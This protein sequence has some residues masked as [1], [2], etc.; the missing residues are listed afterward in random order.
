MSPIRQI[1]HPTDFSESSRAAF[2][3]ACDWA[4]QFGAQLQLLHVAEGISNAYPYLGPPFN[5]AAGW[6]AMIRQK[7]RAALNEWPHP[8]G[9]EGME[10]LRVLR[11]GSPVVQIAEYAKEVH[12][13]LI[14]MGTQGRT[15][16]GHLLLGSVAEN[17]VR[18]APCAVLTI[19]PMGADPVES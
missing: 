15:G 14:V 4:K 10:I 13:D 17:V 7:A 12:S 1:V 19:R 18:R 3:V 16:V 6:E 2:A 5:E 9:Y 8:D 11:T